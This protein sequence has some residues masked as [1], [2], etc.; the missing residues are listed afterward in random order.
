M[1]GIKGRPKAISDRSQQLIID[2][3]LNSGLRREGLAD[4]L[5]EEIKKSGERPPSIQTLKKKISAARHHL[6]PLDKPWHLGWISNNQS[7]QDD[8]KKSY[9]ILPEAVPY[10]LKVQKVQADGSPVTIRQALWISY[11]YSIIDDINLLAQVSWRYAHYE[12]ICE[13]ANTP[14]NTA[15]FDAVLLDDKNQGKIIEIF[16]E[17][18]GPV[19]VRDYQKTIAA[20]TEPKSDT[21]AVEIETIYIYRGNIFALMKG[22]PDKSI[23]L[24][25]KDKAE[26]LNVLK[27]EGFFE[28]VKKFDNDLIRISLKK[29]LSLEIPR[30]IIQKRLQD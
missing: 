14:V 16:D 9:Y 5:R 19:R 28:S 23:Q 24:P 27:R 10:I 25:I 29:L 6:S 8:G 30:E 3:A 18:L 17:K 21:A 20:A 22:K 1:P 7:S 4:M 2:R 26:F 13:I 11:L 15:E 12:R